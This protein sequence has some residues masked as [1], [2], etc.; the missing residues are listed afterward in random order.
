MSSFIDSGAGLVLSTYMARFSPSIEQRKHFIIA[1]LMIWVWCGVATYNE[2][3]NRLCAHRCL[4]TNRLHGKPAVQSLATSWNNRVT[5]TKYIEYINSIH[6]THYSFCHVALVKFYCD[7]ITRSCLQ[8]I[9][10][11]IDTFFSKLCAFLVERRRRK[12]SDG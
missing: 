8:L 2:W 3:T 5:T 11:S 6:D 4:L 9:N 7:V 12:A 1:K 10:T